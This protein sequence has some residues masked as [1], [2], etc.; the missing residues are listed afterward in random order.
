M[1]DKMFLIA[2]ITLFLL[3]L[4]MLRLLYQLKT[5][6]RSIDI[7][8]SNNN[9]WVLMN[10]QSVSNHLDKMSTMILNSY[11]GGRI[12][13]INKIN[14]LPAKTAAILLKEREQKKASFY[15]NKKKQEDIVASSSPNNN[16][17]QQYYNSILEE[18]Q[19]LNKVINQQQDYDYDSMYNSKL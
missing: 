2:G 15:G 16:N 4:I 6:Y 14:E 1:T 5:R 3:I 8:L 10:Y 11:P 9:E 7:R 13:D 18:L 19:Q 17:M 12:V